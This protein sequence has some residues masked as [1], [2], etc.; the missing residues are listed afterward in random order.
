MA[1]YDD[2]FNVLNSDLMVYG[3]AY[4]VGFT[5]IF[6]L[7]RET[8]SNKFRTFVRSSF[9]GGVAV[10]G[11]WVYTLFVPIRFRY[12]LSLSFIV[13]SACNVGKHYNMK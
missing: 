3:S 6:T 9:Y 10:F 1:S 2:I 13:T 12:L 11:S 8:F 4:L 7:N 5:G